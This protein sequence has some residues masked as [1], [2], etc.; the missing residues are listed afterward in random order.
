VPLAT[1]RVYLATYVTIDTGGLLHH[2][3]TFDH[4]L[5]N[6]GEKER[7]TLLILDGRLL[8]VALALRLL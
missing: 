1:D 8:S 6:R 5:R 3:F 4:L 7:E 2:R